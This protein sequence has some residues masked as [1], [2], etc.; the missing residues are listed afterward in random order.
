[1]S[2]EDNSQIRI[3]LDYW[4]YVIQW[5]SNFGEKALP[6]TRGKQINTNRFESLIYSLWACA[7]AQNTGSG[8]LLIRSQES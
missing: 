3:N 8:E 1:M 7:F 6:I 4:D 5:G 2:P